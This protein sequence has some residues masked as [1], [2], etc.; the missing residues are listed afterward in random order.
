VVSVRMRVSSEIV[1]DWS[2]LVLNRS[3]RSVYDRSE[4]RCSEMVYNGSG[5][6]RM[7]WGEGLCE[8]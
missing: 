8:T 1:Y 4:V 5:A 6:L 7:E 3:G 2:G